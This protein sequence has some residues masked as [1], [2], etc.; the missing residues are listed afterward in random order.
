VQCPLI[1][2][3]GKNFQQR[4]RFLH[5]LYRWQKTE[6]EAETHAQIENSSSLAIRL[7]HLF[8]SF[9]GECYHGLYITR[10]IRK[11]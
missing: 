4:N 10:Y 3:S 1:F 9:T 6:R 2:V 8:R 7:I 5:T 11:C